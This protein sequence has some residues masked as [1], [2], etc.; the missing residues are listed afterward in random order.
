MKEPRSISF[1]HCDGNTILAI[2][3]AL[4]RINNMRSYLVILLVFP[5][6]TNASGR[7][8]PLA[9]TYSSD[10]FWPTAVLHHFP[11]TD[12]RAAGFGK[13]D[14][15]PGRRVRVTTFPSAALQTSIFIEM[16]LLYSRANANTL[17][18]AAPKQIFPPRSNIL[19]VEDFRPVWKHI[20]TP[21]QQ[22]HRAA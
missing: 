3:S 10:S 11:K 13:A 14:A 7:L 2:G 1:L 20:R 17:A 22:C 21:V 18:A 5:P 19:H 4:S 12:T 9:S 6:R 8:G 15:Q 16:G